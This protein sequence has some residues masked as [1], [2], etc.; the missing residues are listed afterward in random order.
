MTKNNNF[1]Y[2]PLYLVVGLL[3]ASVSLFFLAIF[4]VLFH[5]TLDST[6]ELGALWSP[7]ETTTINSFELSI[8]IVSILLLSGVSLIT[9]IL[10]GPF[11]IYGNGGPKTNIC[12]ASN[13]KGAK[14]GS[15]GLK[16][17]VGIN[18]KMTLRHLSVKASLKKLHPWFIT[19][20]LD[21]ESCFNVE[22]NS[23]KTIRI[24]LTVQ[25]KF[26]ISLHKKDR[27]IL[28]EIKLY[29]GVG[30][31]YKHGKNSLQYQVKSL[32]D[33]TN[34][35][36]PH[37]DKYSLIT[38]KWADF[39]LFKS[40][41]EMMNRKEHLTYEGLRK[42]VLI[43]AKI[44]LGLSEKL[45]KIFP[46]RGAIIPVP[47]PLVERAK[48]FDPNWVAGF[49][50]GEGCFLIRILK[51]STNITGSQVVLVCKITQH[52][53]DEE[54]MKS[55][56][57][58]FGW[59]R[60]ESAHNKNIGNFI[61]TKFTDITDKVIPF[62]DK[63]QIIGVKALDFIDWCE[64]AELIKNKAHKTP[65]GL[66]EIWKIKMRMNSRRLYNIEDE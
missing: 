21:G 28:E 58:Y 37:F 20:F 45:K 2:R 14:I 62:F 16:R 42:I 66:E 1:Q 12:S 65:E 53:R 40:V 32:H 10:L 33:L 35:I 9:V 64:A 52:S 47:R 43:K 11:S 8:Y 13:T 30:F 25:A 48:T 27:A 3:I 50:S 59:G 23:S 15:W 61:V 60:Y 46:S 31:I 63:Y 24:G 57:S 55:L 19:G 22:I 18:N 56:V 26:Q 7:L 6:V 49:V 4:W 41:I 38:Q 29:F 5:S 34:I 44:N 39:E 36:I 51:S 17:I 54:L